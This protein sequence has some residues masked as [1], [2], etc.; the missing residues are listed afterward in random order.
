M[1]CCRIRGGKSRSADRGHLI[2]SRVI[3]KNRNILFESFSLFV[4]NGYSQKDRIG[5]DRIP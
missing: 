2:P 3:R 4:Y 5:S 1:Y